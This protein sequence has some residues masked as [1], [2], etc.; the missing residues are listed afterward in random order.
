MLTSKELPYLQLTKQRR[1]YSHVP[2]RFLSQGNI[3]KLAIKLSGI[4]NVKIFREEQVRNW[5]LHQIIFQIELL[6]VIPGV[7][8]MALRYLAIE[9]YKCVNGLN[10]K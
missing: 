4:Q 9:V 2:L 5:H 1:V 8:I 6:Y 10:P 7:T 3:L